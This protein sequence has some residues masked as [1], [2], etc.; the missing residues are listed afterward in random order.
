MRSFLV[1][2]VCLLS[3]STSPVAAQM[4]IQPAYAGA[5]LNGPST[6]AMGLQPNGSSN[7][8][9]G[10]A[11][12]NDLEKAELL[13]REAAGQCGVRLS[14][15]PQITPRLQ[16][17]STSQRPPQL[18]YD[19]WSYTPSI[20]RRQTNLSNFVRQSRVSDPIGS[21][22][23]AELFASTDVIASLGRDL[24][25]YGLQ[26]SNLADALTVYWVQAWQTASGSTQDA[27]QATMQA[28]K[29]QAIATLGTVV[30]FA[31][32]DDSRKQQL[33][34]ALFVQAMIISAGTDAYK[35]DA[36]T[37]RQ[38]QTAV[39]NGAL[40]LGLDLAEMRLTPAGFASTN[41]ANPN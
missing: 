35:S 19:F 40:T 7:L 39:R 15:V 26:T 12:S 31:S 25:P 36:T 33:A 34:E 20:S 11:Y 13:A 27:S 24:Q 5:I 18:S 9:C 29:Q 23:M 16:P 3:L 32:F 37:M 1:S 4:P 17:S 41:S 8:I 14:R 22:K 10:Q 6:M 2:F 21:E 30:D 38:F 28:V